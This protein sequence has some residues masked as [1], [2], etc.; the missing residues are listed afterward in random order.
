M[1]DQRSTIDFSQYSDASLAAALERV[2]RNKFPMNYQACL[3][4][5]EKRRKFSPPSPNEN[6]DDTNHFFSYHGT[7]SDLAI[8]LLK[9]LFLT[10]LT[11]GFYSPWART[12]TRRFYWSNTAFKGDRFA[13]TGT[14][15]ELF[16]GWLRLLVFLFPATI[17]INLGSLI[18]PEAY[19]PLMSLLVLPIYIYVFALATYSGL[20][21]RAL[22]TLWRQIRFDVVRD[23]AQAREF[24]LLYFKGVVLSCL[25]LGIYVPF[26]TINKH[27]FLMNR[28]NY[29]GI[30]FSFDGD[31]T[32][33]LLLCFKGLF[34]SILTLGMYLPWYFVNRMQYRMEKT[35]IG[36]NSFHLNISGGRL[37]KYTVVGYLAVICTFGLATPW[38]I[39]QFLHLFVN[40]LSL[41][42]LLNIENVKN[43]AQTGSAVG[44]DLA[45]A[46][47]V[48]FGF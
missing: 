36:Q 10:I 9:N 26:F 5:I 42:G 31:G 4:E 18:L 3:D 1:S 13:Y 39:D 38:V 44:D 15:K 40:N 33:Y 30:K 23:K 35:H 24:N 20:R 37:L 32:E 29:G 17:V 25:T 27:K 7:G 22:R 47:D 19:Q 28:T 48:D 43:I 8:L 14:G 46:Y 16:V 45:A 41:K 2:D 34:L 21:Y 6:S 12:N 11:F